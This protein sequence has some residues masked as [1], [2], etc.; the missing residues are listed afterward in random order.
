[1][2]EI[3]PKLASKSFI[4]DLPLCRVF[5]EDE[6][7]YPWVFLVPRRHE[8]SRIIDLTKADQL[9]LLEELELVQT[10]L[11]EEF[12]LTQLNVAALG[13]RVPQ[14]HVH[15]IGRKTTDPAWPGT[16]WDHPVR[17]PYSS[18][19]KEAMIQLLQAHLHV[20]K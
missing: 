5:M 2:F 7:N 17:T 12:E 4:T 6:K 20:A 9:Q 8:V 3:H 11:W 14:L 1:M 16:V 15:V 19:E 18:E 13:N 10:V